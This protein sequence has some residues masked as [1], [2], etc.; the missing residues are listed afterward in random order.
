MVIVETYVKVSI[1]QL[2]GHDRLLI[3]MPD[4]ENHQTKAFWM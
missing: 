3:E 1:F 2:T 4:I